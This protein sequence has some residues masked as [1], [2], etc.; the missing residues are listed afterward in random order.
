MKKR[1][2]YRSNASSGSSRPSKDSLL[3]EIY[4]MLFYKKKKYSFL[5]GGVT[6]T[7]SFVNSESK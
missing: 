2:T 7:G 4:N 6:Q 5:P 1:N 3:P